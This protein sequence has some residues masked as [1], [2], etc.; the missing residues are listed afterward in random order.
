MAW[1]NSLNP[2]LQNALFAIALLLLAW[3]AASVARSVVTKIVEGVYTKKL[4]SAPEEVQAQKQDIISLLG[5]IVYAVVFMLFLPGALDKLGVSSVSSPIS[6]MASKFLSYLPN[7]IAAILVFVFGL[8]LAKLVKQ[9]LSIVLKKTK[10]DSLQERAGF[11][12]E[13]GTGF[14]DLLANLAYALILV[15][16]VI[17]ALQILKLEAISGPAM[18]M[19]QNI[20]DYVPKIFAAVVL[21][22]FGVF[23]ANLVSKLLD[24]VLE[25]TG[26]DKSLASLLPNET[27][28][29]SNILSSIVNVLINIF[30]VVSALNVL[31][32]EVLSRVGNAVITYLPNIV[33]AILIMLVAWVGTDKL[34]NVILAADGSSKALADGSRVV[35]LIL[36]AFMALQQLGIAPTIV[37]TLFGVVVVALALAFALA[38][39]IGGRDFAKKKLEEIDNKKNNQ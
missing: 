38:F 32:I 27:M 5:N 20:F 3:I 12:G 18:A 36:A 34:R 8:F 23:L 7:I 21:V 28:K 1:F 2:T 31:D 16:F 39:G 6:Q 37:N 9:V 29:A 11:T 19:V 24:G 10:I 25:G 4:N 22:A 35:L 14:S 17:A 26:V 15:I 33:A 30:F 13:T